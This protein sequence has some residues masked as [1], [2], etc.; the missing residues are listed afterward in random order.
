MS[1]KPYSS[2]IERL[3]W[4][5]AFCYLLQ[6]FRMA[7][8]A[9]L[10]YIFLPWN[11]L[12]AWVPLAFAVIATNQNS[13]VKLILSFIVWLLFF[14]NA[15]YIITDLIHLKPRDGWPYWY[16]VFLIYSF[17]LAGFLAG[18]IST[19][20]MYRKLKEVLS[21]LMARLTILVS[22]VLC[23]YGIYMGRFLRWNSWDAITNPFAILSDMV[24][25]LAHPFSNPRTYGITMLSS[26]LVWLVFKVF[27]SLSTKEEA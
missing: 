15:P 26:V 17:A 7:C 3:L 25:S 20:I 5:S 11:L 2:V 8:T 27:E 12:L 18:I 19:L 6:A 21:P 4:L 1:A 22:I 23:G 10:H 24:S 13:K 14:P 9:N 16:D